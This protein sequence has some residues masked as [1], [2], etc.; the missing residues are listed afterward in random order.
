MFSGIR[1][2]VQQH[3]WSRNKL[4]GGLAKCE[5]G[6]ELLLVELILSMCLQQGVLNS[7]KLVT[8]KETKSWCQPAVLGALGIPGAVGPF[9]ET[10]YCLHQSLA[11]TAGRLGGTEQTSALLHHSPAH[12]QE[13][14]QP[15]ST[16]HARAE[17]PA[18][19][20]HPTRKRWVQKGLDKAGGK[21]SQGF[22]MAAHPMLTES[23]LP[24][25][26]LGPCHSRTQPEPLPWPSRVVLLFWHSAS[27]I[28][29]PCWTCRPQWQAVNHE[30][31]SDFMG[32]RLVPVPCLSIQAQA[33]II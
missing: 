5:V 25:H 32:K 3:V 13:H 1:E 20:N 18:C 7:V 19:Q 14:R 16:Y 12:E 24:N 9:S 15:S 17:P 22:R 29:N 28:V 23:V 27:G 26:P 33:A 31:H 21:K 10:S 4:M 2:L 11:G 8:W 30:F 6:E